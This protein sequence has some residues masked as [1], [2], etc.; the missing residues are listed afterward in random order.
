MIKSLQS[1]FSANAIITNL[2]FSF[3][4]SFFIWGAGI[5]GAFGMFALP[6]LI[7]LIPWFIQ[8]CFD[9]GTAAVNGASEPPVHKYQSVLLH[10]FLLT[11]IC[12]GLYIGVTALAGK[13]WATLFLGLLVPAM[14]C[15][16]LVEEEILRA[17]NPLNWLRYIIELKLNYVL[18]SLILIIAA[19]LL[20]LIPSNLWL[21]PK[22]FIYQTILVATCFT[23][24]HLLHQQRI[25]LNIMTSETEDEREIRVTS[26]QDTIALDN[27]TDR[28]FRLSEVHEYQKALKEILD[29]LAQST[30]PLEYAIRIMDELLVWNNPAL[31]AK[32]VPHY[33][34]LLI[35]HNKPAKAFGV[36]KS[37][38]ERYGPISLSDEKA[39]K[40]MFQFANDSGDYELADSLDQTA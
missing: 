39:R 31:S 2:V 32:V 3:F 29:Y 18:L 24:G 22:L 13:S 26:E 28:W 17:I 23:I 40:V 30:D 1:G 9:T 11:I 35:E 7:I 12:Y 8:Y 27:H 19:F 21:W 36:Y 20:N 16:F 33:I 5:A 14:I 34:K 38:V 10:P 15:S 6:A 4:I 25:E 37:I